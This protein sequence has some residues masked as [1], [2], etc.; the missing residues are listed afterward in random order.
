VVKNTVDPSNSI[1]SSCSSESLDAVVENPV[2][3]SPVPQNDGMQVES[4]GACTE[5]LENRKPGAL[6]KPGV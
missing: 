4:L 3:E 1:P 2:L 6:T 5:S